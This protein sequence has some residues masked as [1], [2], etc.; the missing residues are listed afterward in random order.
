MWLILLP[1]FTFH[2]YTRQGILV[3]FLFVHQYESRVKFLCQFALSGEARKLYIS[4]ARTRPSAALATIY[5]GVWYETYVVGSKSFR[6]DIQKPRQME[7]A[8]RDIWCHLESLVHRCEKG[9]WNKGRLCWKIAKLFYFCHLKKLVGPET[10]GLY[11][12]IAFIMNRRSHWTF[13]V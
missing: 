13:A 12:V 11:Y 8:V 6:P 2:S 5:C 7:N 1:H 9:C 4:A 3:S 10:C